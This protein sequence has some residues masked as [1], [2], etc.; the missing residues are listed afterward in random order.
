MY[1][2][3]HI[4]M[5]TCVSRCSCCSCYYCSCC[6]IACYFYVIVFPCSLAFLPPCALSQMLS[7]FLA[8]LLPWLICF[9][10]LLFLWRIAS[11]ILCFR[12]SFEIEELNS[13]LF[14]IIIIPIRCVA[15]NKVSNHKKN[16][17]PGSGVFLFRGPVLTYSY[18]KQFKTA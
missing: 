10:A 17:G 8:T 12:T 11:L 7:C 2:R 5:Y 14:A 1:A 18:T 6:L 13:S 9:L 16:P 4:Q 3:I 15:K